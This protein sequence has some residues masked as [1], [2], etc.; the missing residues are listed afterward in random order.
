[1]DIG[2]VGG[3]E[4][5]TVGA[6]THS[7]KRA[8]PTR[9]LLHGN[10]HSAP[11]LKNESARADRSGIATVAAATTRTR[12]ISESVEVEENDD[13]RQARAGVR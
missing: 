12:S 2:A 4:M 3:G 8:A 1:M 6:T 13:S 5:G 10:V 9:I 11:A 7:S